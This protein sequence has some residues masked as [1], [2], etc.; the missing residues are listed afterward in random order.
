MHVIGGND[1]SDIGRDDISRRRRARNRVL[2]A[3]LVGVSVLVYAVTIASMGS[4]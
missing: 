4:L 1:S 3:A 2:F